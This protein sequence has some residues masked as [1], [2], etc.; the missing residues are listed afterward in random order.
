MHFLALTAKYLSAP[1]LHTAGFAVRGVVDQTS[2]TMSLILI[3][4]DDEISIYIRWEQYGPIMFSLP[5]LVSLSQ[6][7]STPKS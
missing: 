4:N 2:S 3:V 1:L 7:S 6:S 5:S